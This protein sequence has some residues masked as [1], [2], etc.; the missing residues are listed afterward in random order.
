MLP[1]K[2]QQIRLAREHLERPDLLCAP[3]KMSSAE[4]VQRE[5]RA[6][7]G[8]QA[9]SPCGLDDA[10]LQRGGVKLQVGA[11]T[12]IRAVLQHLRVYADGSVG[13]YRVGDLIEAGDAEH[14]RFMQPGHGVPI[15]NFRTAVGWASTPPHSAVTYNTTIANRLAYAVSAVKRLGIADARRSNIAEL[16]AD[17]NENK[18]ITEN[19]IVAKMRTENHGKSAEQGARTFRRVEDQLAPRTAKPDNKKR[20]RIGGGFGL[21]AAG[22]FAANYD[23]D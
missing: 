16:A 14:N 23:S 11:N 8:P 9:T 3:K 4:D 15:L 6:V 19:D 10:A 7:V 13:E 17:A 20:R 1:R 2:N 18:S 12:S 22:G 5:V 21:A